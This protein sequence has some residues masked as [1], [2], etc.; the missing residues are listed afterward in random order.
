LRYVFKKHLPN[1]EIWPKYSGF[2]FAS[3][4]EIKWR[5]K[6]VATTTTTTRTK[7]P[8]NAEKDSLDLC[9]SIGE[10]L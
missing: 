9:L 8:K 5:E 6:N 10:R 4:L 2:S 3:G 1:L 7:T